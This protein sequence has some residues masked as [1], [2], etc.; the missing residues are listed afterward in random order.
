VGDVVE[1]I[2]PE[3][4]STLTIERMQK[5]GAGGTGRPSGRRWPEEA[6]AI[7]TDVAPGNGHRV[8]IALP[9]GKEGA[10]LTRLD[11]AKR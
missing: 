5:V 4:N 8:L 11:P 1:L 6:T 2:T 9:P 3:G 10:F 7:E